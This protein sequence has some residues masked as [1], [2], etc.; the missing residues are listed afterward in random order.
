MGFKPDAE[1]AFGNTFFA[2]LRSCRNDF[3]F[4]H[5]ILE[6]SPIAVAGYWK[7]RT[8]QMLHQ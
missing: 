6:P 2:F 7:E 4:L 5:H 1:G 3:T 8:K